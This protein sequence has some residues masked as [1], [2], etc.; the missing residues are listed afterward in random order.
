MNFYS[1]IFLIFFSIII[2]IPTAN[3]Q[4][5]DNETKQKS[6]EVTINLTGDV[7]VMHVID[8][9]D[10]PLQIDLIDG[11]ITN[12]S[13][14]DKE[15]NNLEYGEM[16]NN[17][18]VMIMPS[19]QD[20]IIEYHLADKLILTNNV[21]TWEFLYLESTAFLFPEEVDL[22]FVN[23]K[24][25]YLGEKNGINC[26]GC[27]MVL[28]Y[29]LDEPSIF[30]R[31]KMKN[32]EFLIEFRTWAEISKF[33]FEPSS[34]EMSFEVTGNNDYVTAMIPADLLSGPYQ[35]LLDE[36]KIRFHEYINNG[37]HV[38]LNI[39]PQNSGEISVIGSIVPDINEFEIDSETQFSVEYLIVGFVISGI[40]I[41]GIFFVK[42]KKN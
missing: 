31:V 18:S 7:Q 9:L 20:T 14:K 36:E 32:S 5:L 30:E 29:S 35:V 33:N 21:W 11:T 10:L 23:E 28:E 3:A 34:A 22:I 6:V 2:I 42:R 25:A 19:N 41:V 4:L 15:G 37:T 17:E 26:H 27:Q 39:R 1:V 40:V 38:W 16:T 24:P 12:L 13:V 8:D